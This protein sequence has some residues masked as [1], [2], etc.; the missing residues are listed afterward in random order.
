MPKKKEEKQPEPDRSLAVVPASQQAEALISQAINKGVPVETMERL[1][2][3]RKDLKQEFARDAF[4]KAMAEF[5]AECPVIK[6]TKVVKNK[7]GSRRYA[8]APLDSIVLQVRFLL[9]KHGFSYTIDAKVGEADV[10]AVCRVV[11]ELSHS[12]E[13][14]FKVP[15][16]A[17]A[18]MNESQKFASALTFAKRYAFCNAFGIL[19]GDEDDDANQAP[20]APKL[21][22]EQKLARAKTMIANAS[23]VAGLAE[24]A[25]KLGTNTEYSPEEKAELKSM[26]RERIEI[27]TP[28]NEEAP[29]S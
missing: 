1:L 23:D 6:K 11:H 13:S 7:D 24:W 9:Q 20:P 29:K 28:K 2:A 26:I 16:D 21:T 3:M 5:Q 17:G 22:K 12:E 14:S 25:K 8:Y 15:V 27:L 4:N 10:E 19:T 18:F